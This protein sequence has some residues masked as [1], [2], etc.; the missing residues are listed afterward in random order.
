[1]ETKVDKIVEE[2]EKEAHDADFR[3]SALVNLDFEKLS[4][5]MAKNKNNCSKSSVDCNRRCKP[6]TLPWKMEEFWEEKLIFKHFPASEGF[7]FQDDWWKRRAFVTNQSWNFLW[8]YSARTIWTLR[9]RSATTFERLTLKRCW[10]QQDYALILTTNSGLWAYSIGD[11]GFISKNPHEFWFLE[12][13]DILPQ[14]LG[15]T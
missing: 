15:N 12:E 4:K 10:T 14:L 8:I 7:C 1:M 11:V 13:H 5:E 6:R 9:L 3:N 2:T